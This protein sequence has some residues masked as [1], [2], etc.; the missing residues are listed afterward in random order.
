VLAQSQAE[1]LAFAVAWTALV[2]GAHLCLS[3]DKGSLVSTAF[4][5]LQ[6][7]PFFSLNL[8]WFFFDKMIIQG[9]LQKP[10]SIIC[11]DDES[12]IVCIPFNGVYFF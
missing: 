7:L 2:V 12:S 1:G 6:P 10:A 5:F 9:D 4:C 3:A 11:R 8:V